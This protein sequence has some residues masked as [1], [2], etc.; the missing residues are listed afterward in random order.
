VKATA[1]RYERAYS[2]RGFWTKV[3]KYGAAA[4]KQVLEPALTLY[5]AARDK[6]TPAWAR[7]TIYGA[8]GYFIF[9]VDAIS[10]L[11]PVAGYGDD[12]GVLVAALAVVTAHV[13]PSHK[14]RA[15]ETTKEWL[16]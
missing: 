7:T 4:G 16:S 8:L 13:R 3:R 6:D 14:R 10:D 12:L 1:S 15:K 2:S 5:Y 9:P 11:I